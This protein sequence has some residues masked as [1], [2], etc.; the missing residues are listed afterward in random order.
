MYIYILKKIFIYC[1]HIF[2]SHIPMSMPHTGMS[3][4]THMNMLQYART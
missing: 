4:A 2:M 3:H 1:I